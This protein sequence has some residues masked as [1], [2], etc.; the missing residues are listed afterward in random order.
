MSN[1]QN[2]APS[3]ETVLL[4]NILVVT[5]PAHCVSVTLKKSSL[6]HLTVRQMHWFS[7]FCGLIS[8]TMPSYVTFLTFGNF[9]LDMKKILLFPFSMRVPKFWSSLPRSL[10]N[11]F[12]HISASGRCRNCL[13]SCYIP[14]MISMTA[15]VSKCMHASCAVRICVARAYL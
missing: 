3:V 15:L 2:L 14:V 4:N 5:S 10:S 6:S 13:Y 11:S 8:A 1:M 7:I 9:P 12:I